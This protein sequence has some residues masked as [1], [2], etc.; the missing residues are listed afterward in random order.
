MYDRNVN[1]RTLDFGVIGLLE[2]S[3]HLYDVATRSWWSQ[4]MGSAVSGPLEGERLAKVSSTMTTWKKWKAL[5]PDTTAYIKRSVPYH[6]QSDF[7]GEYIAEMAQKEDGPVEDTDLIIG[8]EGH[9]EA[10]A[11]L[12]R[13]LAKKR[14]LNDSLEGHPIVVFL[15]EDLTTARILDR[16]VGWRIF[17]WTFNRRTLTCSPA[18]NDLLR[19][20]ETGSLWDPMTG[21]AVSGSMQG[22]Q[23]QPFVSTYSLWFAWNK[24]RPES[25]LVMVK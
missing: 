13:H 17:N 24:Y 25:E 14:V 23:L 19:D 20:A 21:E 18:E 7:S 11:Y 12:I 5:Y 6:E 9:E 10:R 1:G 15:S 8:V 4:L 16:S 3:L 22:K 2:G